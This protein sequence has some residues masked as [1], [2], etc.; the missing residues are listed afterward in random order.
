MASKQDAR[1]DAPRPSE[2]DRELA[3]W[4]ELLAQAGREL[5]E[6]LTTALERVATLT[7]TGR[8][9]RAGLRTLLDEVD[10]ARQAGIWCQ[11]IS[12][13]ASGRV[14]QT[15]ER[16][17][18]TN[19]IQSVLAHRARELQARGIHIVQSLHELEVQVDAS[20]LHG[21]LNALVEWWLGCAQGLVDVRI[22]TGGWSDNASL[23]CQF[24]HRSPDLPPEQH[25][26]ALDSMSWHLLD[27]TARTLGLV[28]QRKITA[29]Q[30]QL[31]LEFPRAAH[32]LVAN[33]GGDTPNAGFADSI[34]SKPLA[35]CHVL[36][37]A[38]RRD[39][40]GLVRES[41]KSMGLV[42]D[43]V[44]SVADAVEFCQEGL[45]HGIVFEGKL[46]TPAFMRL[47]ES[48]RRE[49]PEFVFIELLDEGQAFEISSISPTGM[50]RVGHSAVA[51][52]LPSALVYEL[53][54]IM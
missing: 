5:A 53:T 8:I 38:A 47:V 54:R 18:L 41:I 49:V 3:R 36:V 42:I 50:A 1:A 30:V 37:M 35:G 43:F 33:V 15:H 12:R 29:S 34:N 39:V 23:V 24:Q 44:N 46:K 7:T 14:R 9:D 13:L 31:R 4:Q 26:P 2:P 16:V 40:R 21:L 17:H 19:T 20:M 6:P 45:P 27:Q 48:V 22:D 52:S 25:N 32:A 10:R 51:T 11:Q 28:Q